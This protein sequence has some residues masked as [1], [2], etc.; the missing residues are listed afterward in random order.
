MADT[1]TESPDPTIVLT[2]VM[3]VVDH[4][5]E[6]VLYPAGSIYNADA[7]ELENLVY[8]VRFAQWASGTTREGALPPAR[9]GQ[10]PATRETPRRNTAVEPM[11][12]TG[13]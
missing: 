4:T 11:K 6:G 10:A 13:R 8:H 5:Y 2:S 7:R 1:K 12:T 3:S 9:G